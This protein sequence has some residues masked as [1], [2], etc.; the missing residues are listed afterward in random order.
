[1]KRPEHALGLQPIKRKRLKVSE[2]EEIINRV[3]L[4]SERTE[5]VGLC[6]R[7]GLQQNRH[8]LSHKLE[9]RW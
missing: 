8:S 2:R 9:E 1:M 3:V 6:I 5:K 7:I 4:F